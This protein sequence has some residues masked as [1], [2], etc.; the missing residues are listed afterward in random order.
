MVFRSLVSGVFVMMSCVGFV[1]G[2]PITGDWCFE[3]GDLSTSAG[4]AM[5][6]MDGAAGATAQQTQFGKASG[7][8]IPLPGGADVPVMK[9][10]KCSPTM[11]YKLFPGTTASGGVD[12]N[13]YTVMMDLYLPELPSGYG[14]LFNTSPT[15]ANDGELFINA[16]G[17]IGISGQYEGSIQPGAWHRIVWTVAGTALRKYVD[18]H[19][20]GSQTLSGSADGRWSLVAGGNAVLFGDE[21]NES[22]SGYVARVQVRDGVLTPSEVAELGGLYEAVPQM[23]TA[24]YLQNMRTDGMTVMW[25]TDSD[26]TGTLEYGAGTSYGTSVVAVRRLTP[27]GTYVHSVRLTGL[28]PDTPYHYRV[29]N[30]GIGASEDATFRTAPDS[31]LGDFSF[32]FWSDSQGATSAGANEPTVSIMKH[33]AASGVSFAVTS[34]DLAEDGG[35]PGAVRPYYLNRVCKYLGSVVP[36]FIAWGNH[37]TYTLPAPSGSLNFIRYM[38]SQPSEDRT[39]LGTATNAGRG[40]FT[41]TYRGVFFVCI[42]NAHHAD[43][44]N[45]WLDAQLA[46]PACKNARMRIAVIHVPPYCDLWVDGDA[47]LRA[48]LVPKLEANGFAACLSG[49]THEYERGFLNGVNYVIA[50]G[51]SW[52]D[53]GETVVKDW[54]HITV[55]GA[56]DIVGAPHGGLLHNYVKFDIHG[57]E[58]T[59]AMHTFAVDGTY[60]G[61]K[62]TFTVV[63]PKT[64]INDWSMF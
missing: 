43:I 56:H 47:G 31:D 45:G 28:V 18:G 27:A 21:S 52:L 32:G 11:G 8:G 49:H 7:F 22:L 59:G 53:Y 4:Q 44:T 51:S 3:N 17:G 58:I 48:N 40:S 23:L 60:T 63:S 46:L 14:S 38:A 30:A 13:Y 34:G 35:S 62:D 15:N 39:D 42:D 6:Y 20:V 54:P 5:Q 37:D 36:Y 61:V 64:N 16:A 26:C 33:M 19:A 57:G 41:F 24:P 2:A 1:E 29:T 10:P 25:E 9:F 55:G 50:G 12:T